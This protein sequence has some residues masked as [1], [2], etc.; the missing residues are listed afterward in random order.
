VRVERFEEVPEA[1]LE[2]YAALY[3]EVMNQQPM[4]EVAYRPRVT[5][6]SRRAD[7]KRLRR[8]GIVWITLV[9]R[10]PDGAFSGLTETAYHPEE[11]PH[12]HQMLTGVREAYRGRGLGKWLKALMLCH[13]R[14]RF[15]VLRFI[16][17]G[18][19]DVNAAMHAI[20]RGMGFKRHLAETAFKW[21]VADLC[22][23]LEVG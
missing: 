7:E 14:D 16:A 9:T 17:T 3:T 18:N 1:D 22:R 12:A 11:P 15:P 5:P 6:E 20:N 21:D 10:E 8:Q 19:A 23:T 13:L 2:S 4:G